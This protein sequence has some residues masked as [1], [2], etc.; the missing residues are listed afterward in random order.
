M[1]PAA[2]KS[3]ARK[4]AEPDA[5]AN[6]NGAETTEERNARV[7]LAIPNVTTGQKVTHDQVV[8][9]EVLAEHDARDADRAARA[10]TILDEAGY[11]GLLTAGVLR[12]LQPLL[13]EPLNPRHIVTTGP[14][15]KGKPYVSTGIQSVQT[16]IER[17][18]EV[19][20][21]AHFRLLPYWTPDGTKCRVHAII[22]NDLQWAHL[23]AH[24]DLVP[25]TL[26]DGTVGLA[27]GP[28]YAG[29]KEAEVIAH[30][31]GWGGHGRGTAPADTLKG[32]ET[33][34]AKRTIARLGPGGHVYELDFE[35]DPHQPEAKPDRDARRRGAAKT[36]TPAVQ[37]QDAAA[38]QTELT[39]EQHEA[40]IAALLAA[41]DKLK[42][43]RTAADD[44]M[45][46]LGSPPRRRHAEL[47]AATTERQ[48]R[49]IVHRVSMAIDR[50][51]SDGDDGQGTLP[52]A[53]S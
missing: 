15:E 31:D 47:R 30:A 5:P 53:G 13:D 20:G 8:S 42:D 52:V 7:R 28:V 51:A 45:K 9:A 6:G 38:E 44:A 32:A 11:D 1:P 34:A 19:I 22:G 46:R 26:L 24:G 40:A 21:L 48:L 16:Q 50:D 39:P 17:L 33:N 27:S 4:P 36:S 12:K 18:N 25:Y 43:A 41:D 35:D 23:D 10:M 49:D 3:S 29:V 37:A 14:A 2:K